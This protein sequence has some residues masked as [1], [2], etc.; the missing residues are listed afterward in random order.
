M[1]AETWKESR[2]M[3]VSKILTDG[4]MVRPQDIATSTRKGPNGR[5][6]ELIDEITRAV[7]EGF[8]PPRKLYIWCIKETAAEQ[9]DCT[10]G[11]RLQA[12]DA[13]EG[14]GPQPPGDLL[15]PSVRKG[16]WDDGSPRLALPH[17][18][19][20][21]RPLAGL[22]TRRRDLQAVQGERSRNFRVPAA[23]LQT[24]DAP[25]LHADLLRAA[26]RTRTF[27]PTLP[28]ARSFRRWIG[29]GPT[30]TPSTGISFSPTR[31]T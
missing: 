27:C 1:D 29:V 3:T 28:T 20:R 15:L 4:R 17:L 14:A 7:R 24:R 9:A 11:Q 31:S 18:Q 26:Q 5:V 22:A 10:D 21:L 8:K 6:Q 19:R 25:P 30:P 16:E 13:A 2:N 12:P 23:L